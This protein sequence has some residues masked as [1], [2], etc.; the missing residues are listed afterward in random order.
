[1]KYLEKH[2]SH[3]ISIVLYIFDSINQELIIYVY[4]LL[5]IK[6]HYNR[7]LIDYL[8]FLFC[9]ISRNEDS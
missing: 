8:W 5:I 2:P 1:M 6:S 3:V 4:E 9:L 7:E